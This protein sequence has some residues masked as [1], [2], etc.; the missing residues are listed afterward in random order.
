MALVHPAIASWLARRPSTTRTSP[1]PNVV[2]TRAAEGKTTLPGR[3]GFAENEKFSVG[4]TE[5]CTTS[6]I[7]AMGT[8]TTATT[9]ASVAKSCR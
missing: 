3:S 5:S 2:A 8:V 9:A 7:T 1:P 6:S 4:S